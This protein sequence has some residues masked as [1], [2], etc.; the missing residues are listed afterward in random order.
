MQIQKAARQ[1][2]SED[3]T[4]S[5]F[6]DI[7]PYFADLLQRKI[8]AIDAFDKWLLDRSELDAVLEEDLAW[9][10]IKMSIDTANEALR[11]SYTQF[12]TQIQPRLAPLDDQLNEKLLAS[13]FLKE[14]Q[15][16]AHYIY[17]R[18]IQTAKNLYREENVAI[19]AALS[20]EAQQ[21]GAIS[22][23]QQIEHRGQKLTMQQAALLLKEQ[24]EALRK[25]VFEKMAEA[26]RKDR[27]VLDVLFSSLIE[28]R[29]QLAVN[30]GFENYRDYK[31]LAMGRFDYTKEDCFAFH[32]AIKTHIVP[33]VRSI[34]EKKLSFLGK[35]KFKPWDTEVDPEGKKALKPFDNGEQMLQG[36]IQMFDQIDPYFGS[37]LRTMQMLGHLDLDSKPGKAPGGYN[38]PL[39]EIGV[40]FIFM[41]A[42]GSQR[43]L[44]T[45]VHEGGHAIHSFLSRE[46]HLTA[47]KNIPSE[48]AELASMSMELLS[49]PQWKH[50]YNNEDHKRAMREQLE[51]TLKVL[52]W[53]AQI[54]AFQHWVYENPK[55]NLTDR[56]LKW[57]ELSAEYGTGLTDW[58]GYTD[59]IESS[60]Q[61]QLHLFEVPFYYI[62]YGIA[63][64]GALGVWKNSLENYAQAIEQ[65][66]NALALGYT[67]PMNKIYQTAGI[68]FDFS[69]ERLQSLAALLEAELKK[70]N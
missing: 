1:F 52:P 51:G 21:Y 13:P 18:S 14:K 44:E 66:K 53:I 10:Y 6:E 3:L 2:L 8:D 69:S 59:L 35:D 47:F 48:V 37:C 46:L 49:M 33:L 29:H 16:E 20:E 60:W 24:D 67:V 45:M 39:Y 28:K 63:Q 61:R 27:A 17:F 23:A 65:Y 64:L 25:E 11:D 36:T 54:D 9:R 34:Q 70:L 40:P 56:A 32:E 7:E 62:E 58:D 68:P 19:E 50:F 22:A 30:A 4:I 42:V 26:R 31:F 5:N 43:D 15:D 57:S 55:H 12:V 41:N 38:Y